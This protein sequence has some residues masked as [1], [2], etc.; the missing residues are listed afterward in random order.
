MAQAVLFL[1]A[2]FAFRFSAAATCCLWALMKADIIAASSG[3]YGFEIT[4][5]STPSGS[6]TIPVSCMTSRLLFI[7][8]FFRGIGFILLI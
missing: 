6:M 3:V 8:S 1:A 4:V 5:N 7:R 2:R